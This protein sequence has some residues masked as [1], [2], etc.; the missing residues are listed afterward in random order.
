MR[1]LLAGLIFALLCGN[2]FSQRAVDPLMLLPDVASGKL[3]PIERRLPQQPL[4]VPVESLGKHGGTLHSLVG[5]SRDTRLLVVYGYA[6]LVGYD[7]N[8]ELVPD[9]LE[10]FDVQEGRIFTLRLRKG[11]RWSDGHPFTAEDFRYYW[12]DVAN[13]K[14]LAPSGPPRDL[15]VDGQPPKFE[16]LSETAVRYSWHK[17][18]PQFLPRQAGASPLFI[19][20]PAHF[21]KRFHKKY[22][23]KIR[24]EEAEG[25][26]KRRW[27]AVHNR[28]DNLYEFDNPDLPTLQPWMNTTRPPA[29]RFVAV[30]NPYFHRVDQR[31]LQ[32]PYIDRFVLAVADPK[33]IPAKT[34]AG[35]ADLQARDVHFNNYTFLKQAEKQNNYRTLLWRPG[36]GSHFALFPNLN[37]NDP[38]WRKLLRDVRFRRALSLAIDRSLVNQVLYFGLA[39]ESNNT[40]LPQ[41]P[42]YREAYRERW[43]RYDRKEASRLLDEVG[44]KRG[45]DGVR[46][47]PD[48]RPLEIIVE[49]AGESTEQTDVLELVRETWREVGI[50]LF[51]K[52]SQREAFRMRVFSGETIMSVWSGLE[53]G[54]ATPDSS[55]DE[56]APTSQTQMQWP[57]FGQHYETGGK[58]GEAPDLPEAQELARLYKTWLE[59]ASR[60]QRERAWHAMLELHAEQ[61]LTIGVVS[62]VPQ[63]VVARDTLMNV[64]AQGFYNWDPGAFFGIYRPDT[65][66]FR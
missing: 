55:P 1:R 59:S 33:L 28:V 9:L 27:S 47:L 43:A 56:L 66:W 54:L 8:L 17:P 35:E 13:N 12:E 10:S 20:R 48:G 31:G 21:L 63:P 32:L 30:R 65:F 4:V 5:R 52:P 61:Q 24:K 64:P 14:E 39:I 26:A 15:L 60:E 22:S 16:V 36:K 58:A 46:R 34:G 40:V 23:E 62:G 41:S 18:N 7:R 50:K 29:D 6:R 51:S 11:H 45:R 19:Y 38:V 53:N 2:S 49:T 37:A 42:L 57:K 25:T 3:P 44:L